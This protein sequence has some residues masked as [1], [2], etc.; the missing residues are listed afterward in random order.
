MLKMRA[1]WCAVS[2]QLTTSSQE[3]SHFQLLFQ[4]L[5]YKTWYSDD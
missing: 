5:R 3:T 2:V 1:I 4:A